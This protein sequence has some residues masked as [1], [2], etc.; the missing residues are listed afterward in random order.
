QR[1][2]G[3]AA[4]A[5]S[6]GPELCGEPAQ[7]DWLPLHGW[8]RGSVRSAA[9]GGCPAVH[10]LV[11]GPVADS[12]GAAFGAGWGV[13]IDDECQLLRRAGVAVSGRFGRWGRWLGRR[14]RG[15]GRGRGLCRLTRRGVATQYADS[16]LVLGVQESAGQPAEDV[17][18]DRLGDGDL[19]VLREAAWLEAHV[20]ELVDHGA[21]GNPVL[22]RHRGLESE[23]VHQA[24]DGRTLFGHCQEDLAGGAIVIEADGHVAL[25]ALDVELVGERA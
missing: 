3:R 14:H 24:G 17:V 20:A 13:G 16:F 8:G 7:V 12:D 1:L 21:E 18:D 23:G 2:A 11:A 6:L 9:A 4:G 25:V 10:A 15:G 5:V 19:R 22:E